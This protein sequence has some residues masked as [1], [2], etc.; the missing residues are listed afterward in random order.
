M[1]FALQLFGLLSAFFS[2]FSYVPYVKDIFRGKAKPERASWI[3][4]AVLVFI[5]FFSQL[6]KGAT[7]SLSL[8]GSQLIGITLICLLSF[9]FGYGRFRKKDYF[10]LFAAGIGL[11]LWYITREA[12]IALFITIGIDCIG[13]ILT[14]EKAFHHSESEP[15]AMWVMNFLSGFFATLAVGSL[16]IVLL[17][18][19]VYTVV[20]NIVVLSAIYLGKRKVDK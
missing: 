14:A 3:I 11:V 4:W 10:A 6:S 16:N 19:P 2:I 1:L 5:Q 7:Y 18:Y 12:A 17:S 9:K 8:S 13:G 20:L 15:P